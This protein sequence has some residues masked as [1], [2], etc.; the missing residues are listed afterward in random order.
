MALR[1]GLAARERWLELG[2][3][4][5]VLISVSTSLLL[6]YA[7]GKQAL[8]LWGAVSPPDRAGAEPLPSPMGIGLSIFFGTALAV[9]ALLGTHRLPGIKDP[10]P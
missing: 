10:R 4:V 5:V 6:F 7:G 9:I 2:G 3:W 1:P 8:D